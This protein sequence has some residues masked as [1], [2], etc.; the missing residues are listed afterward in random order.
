MLVRLRLIIVDQLLLDLPW[1]VSS[2]E[3]L[4]MTRN[5]SFGPGRT[6]DDVDV[7]DVDDDEEGAGAYFFIRHSYGYGKLCSPL[8]S[9]NQHGRTHTDTLVDVFF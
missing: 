9:P 2:L 5:N 4:R 7:H 1:F 3:A 8:L 6:P